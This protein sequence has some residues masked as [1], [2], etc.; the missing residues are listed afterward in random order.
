M[1]FVKQQRDYA[2]EFNLTMHG[3][4]LCVRTFSTS[5]L[6]KKAIIHQVTT[7]LSVQATLF[8]SVTGEFISDNNEIA[9]LCGKDLKQKK[10]YGSNSRHMQIEF[11][12]DVASTERGW[13]LTYTAVGECLSYLFDFFAG[14]ECQR[15]IRQKHYTQV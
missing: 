3:L 11:H 1:T 7:M 15:R 10:Y 6:R 13:N 12:S 8:P 14:W 2:A 9:F 4:N 5:P